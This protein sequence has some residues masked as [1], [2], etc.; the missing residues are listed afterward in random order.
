MRSKHCKAYHINYLELKAIHL[1]IKAYNN[2]WKGCKNIR[3]R[4]DNTTAIEYVSNMG[5][6]VSSSCDRLTKEIMTYSPGRNA[7]LSAI[8]IPG[9]ESNETDYMSRF[10]NDNTEY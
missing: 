3:I 7:W 2:L 9:K 4:S 6:L 10:L 1:A 5:G 8:H